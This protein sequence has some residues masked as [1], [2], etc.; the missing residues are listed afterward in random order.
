MGRHSAQANATLQ[1]GEGRLGAQA[2]AALPPHEPLALD[3]HE[4]ADQLGRLPKATWGLRTAES[5]PPRARGNRS[6]DG[7]EKR[8]LQKNIRRTSKRRARR[9]IPPYCRTGWGR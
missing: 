1:R 4:L 7:L 5:E 8:N 9:T 2:S 6:Y 3:T